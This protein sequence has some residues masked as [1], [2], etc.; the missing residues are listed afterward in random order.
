M[1]LIALVR[2]DLA[3]LRKVACLA[4]ETLTSLSVFWTHRYGL[5]FAQ[6]VAFEPQPS[7]V[8]IGNDIRFARSSPRFS[9]CGF[10]SASLPFALFPSSRWTS[11]FQTC[12]CVVLSPRK[13]WHP[14]HLIELHRYDG[15]SCLWTFATC[16]ACC[17]DVSILSR[18]SV[19]SSR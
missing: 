19:A 16:L 10:T 3:D 13:R 6:S 11:G 7:L 14:L 2:W 8:A 9:E 18:D 17:R 5:R 1:R 4:S 15:T 12:A